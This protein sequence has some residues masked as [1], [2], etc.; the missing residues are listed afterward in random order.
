MC[1]AAIIPRTRRNAAEPSIRLKGQKLRNTDINPADNCPNIYSSA[2][3]QAKACAENPGCR[4]EASYGGCRYRWVYDEYQKTRRGD[5]KAAKLRS[6]TQAVSFFCMICFA[7]IALAVFNG[8]LTEIPIYGFSASK[9]SAKQ[10]TYEAA[11]TTGF[12]AASFSEIACEAKAA[13]ETSIEKIGAECTATTSDMSRC[14]GLPSGVLVTSAKAKS[15]LYMNDIITAV[16]DSEEEMDDGTPVT[17]I[18]TPEELS[19]ALSD[20]PEGEFVFLR[21]YRLGRYFTIEQEIYGTP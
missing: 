7:G 15:E 10:Q 5:L 17:M 11:S 14:Y 13:P 6:A 3:S 1:G 19:A 20:Y 2:D 12:T 18:R 21:V 9:R 16:A 8:I 4:G